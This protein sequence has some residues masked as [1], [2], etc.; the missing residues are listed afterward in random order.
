[1]AVVGDRSV[2][3]PEFVPVDEEV[4]ELRFVA[5][6]DEVTELW[7]AHREVVEHQVELH[8]DVQGVQ[9]VEVVR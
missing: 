1:M 2:V 7:R 4:G 8:G 9:G 6:L 3:R 5:V